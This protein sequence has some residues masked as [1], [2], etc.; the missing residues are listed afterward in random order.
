MFVEVAVAGE[1]D[2]IVTGN[3]KH[4]RPRHGKLSAPVLSP[5]AFVDRLRR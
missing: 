2:A 5:R 1:A 4:F 3:L